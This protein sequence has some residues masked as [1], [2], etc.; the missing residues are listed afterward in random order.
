VDFLGTKIEAQYNQGISENGDYN[1]SRFASFLWDLHYIAKNPLTGNGFA[2]ETRYADDPQLV[3][4]AENGG[5]IAEGDGFSAFIASA[6]IIGMLWYLILIYRHI[7]PSSRK[8]AILWMVVIIIL[9][10]GEDLMRFPFF[11]GLPFFVP[12]F[13]TTDE[14]NEQD[15]YLSYV[16]Q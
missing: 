7:R 16:L 2:P 8:D 10:Q 15:R 11:F 5:N 14:T 9:L 12:L 3:K 1:P 6:G 13:K 4:L